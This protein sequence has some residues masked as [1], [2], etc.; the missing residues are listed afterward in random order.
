MTKNEWQNV[1]ESENFVIL[2]ILAKNM[3]SLKLYVALLQLIFLTYRLFKKSF[4]NIIKFIASLESWIAL[5]DIKIVNIDPGAI[6]G[7]KPNHELS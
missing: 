7:L 6:F 5:T 3:H 1:N 4:K 2:H